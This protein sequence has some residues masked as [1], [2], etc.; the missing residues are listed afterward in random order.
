M[1]PFLVHVYVG[2]I[3]IDAILAQQPFSMLACIKITCVLI[4]TDIRAHYYTS[5]K[6][7]SP[8]ILLR[9]DHV[10]PLLTWYHGHH[11]EQI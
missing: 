1:T 2:V 4:D 10:L 11:A 8:R 7:G 6:A 5:Q 9:P 3:V